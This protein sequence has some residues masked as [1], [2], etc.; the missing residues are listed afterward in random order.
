[1][2]TEGF[3]PPSLY[4]RTPTRRLLPIPQ[5]G[6]PD[7]RQFS[8]QSEAQVQASVQLFFFL[9]VFLQHVLK[10]QITLA[11]DKQGLPLFQSSENSKLGRPLNLLKICGLYPQYHFTLP[12]HS[13]TL[14]CYLLLHFLYYYYCYILEG[15]GPS[16]S[17]YE[18]L[19]PSAKGGKF[20]TV[21]WCSLL[22]FVNFI[23][24]LGKYEST[25]IQINI[26][27]YPKINKNSRK[28]F[29][30]NNLQS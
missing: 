13:S 15:K 7:W 17:S 14:K 5:S 6:A 29:N 8:L 11:G 30:L 10:L 18:G 21:F 16:S 20:W 27:I 28:N 3:C 9:G 19:R 26:Y 24:D 1:M 2:S 23:V 25:K 22:N 4:L 12:L